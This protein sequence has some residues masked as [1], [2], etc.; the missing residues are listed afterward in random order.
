MQTEFKHNSK[1][2]ETDWSENEFTKLN[3]P[4]LEKLVSEELR[5]DKPDLSKEIAVLAKFY[6]IHMQFDRAK[7]GAEKDWMYMLRINNPGGGPITRAQWQKI[8]E[9]AEK[10]T[11]DPDGNTSIRLSTRQAIQFHWLDKPGMLDIVKTMAEIGVSALNGSG[12]N[13]RNTTACPLSHG[14]DIFDANKLGHEI[15]EYFQLP[16]EPFVRIFNIDSEKIKKPTKSFE[17]SAR[18]WAKTKI[19]I[20][21]AHF[22]AETNKITMDNCVELR[23]NEIGIAPIVNDDKVNEFQI[24]LGGGQGERIAAKTMACL[25]LPFCKVTKEKLMPVLDAIAK[26]HQEY[27]DRQNRKW[28][29]LKYLVKAK[30]I[31]WYRKEAE[32]K[33]GFELDEPYEN[34]DYG[35]RQLHHGWTTL[36]NGLLAYGAFIEN[37]RITD[38]SPNGKLKTMVRELMDTYPIELMVTANQDILF[39]NIPAESKE[40]FEA[41]LQKHS[42]G[43]RNGKPYSK[44]RLLSGACVALNTCARSYTESERFEP[45]LIDEL[46]KLG[47]S[48]LTESIGVTGCERQCFRPAT[49][50]I[51]LVGSGRNFYQLKL[52]GTDDAHNQG[53]PIIDR[54]ENKIY[55]KMI[56]RDKVAT[57]I[58]ALLKYYIQHR[59]DE[60][61]SLGYFNRRIGLDGL[62][63]FFKQNESTKDLM[64]VGMP[65]T[66]F[67]EMNNA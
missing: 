32:E 16:T 46:E 57:V 42:Y 38:A 53:K 59:K 67:M 24:Y 15:S 61:E 13:L 62:I 36:P 6:G 27:G 3:F 20:T 23:I 40:D 48:D 5:N 2:P 18:Y 21:A 43:Q 47:W 29:R 4:K 60:N 50:S 12:D 45:I 64:K 52:M 41:I 8:D 54:A 49:K 9:L 51:G 37:G 10:Y 65:A 33:L 1:T 14:S 55:L 66:F 11:S 26:V 31:E 56:P 25:G 22:N 35:D 7:V 17:Y 28:S 63:E 58:D 19:A 34:H 39:M 30:G 44:L